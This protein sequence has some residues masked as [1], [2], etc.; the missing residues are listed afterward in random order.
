[1]DLGAVQQTQ[2]TVLSSDFE[3][4]ALNAMTG[5]RFS[6]PL[7][8]PKTY[9]APAMSKEEYDRCRQNGL[10][11]KCKKPGHVARFC[12]SQGYNK[13]SYSKSKGNSQAR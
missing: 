5:G 10:C 13:D 9:A 8:T 12:T 2:A 11:L 7:S 1:M 4:A 3:Q 6:R